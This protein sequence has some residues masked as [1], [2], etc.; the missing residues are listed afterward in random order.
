MPLRWVPRRESQH[1]TPLSSL[2]ATPVTSSDELTVEE[3]RQWA[4]LQGLLDDNTNRRRYAF[5]LLIAMCIQI[6]FSN[7]VLV[8]YGIT[9]RWHLPTAVISTWFGVSVAQVIT[10]VLVI[11][12]YLFPNRDGP[13]KPATG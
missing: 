5:W 12:H 13:A 3:R 7:V 11:V 8:I 2:D 1:L 6:V 10:V 9:V 4:E